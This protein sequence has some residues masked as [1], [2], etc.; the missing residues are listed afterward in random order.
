MKT[1]YNISNGS[2]VIAY[3]D[4]KNPDRIAL[5]AG[6]TEIAPPT[7]DPNT[8][9]CTFDGTQWVVAEIPVP[10]PDPIPEP[11]AAMDQLR[12][13]RNQLLAQTDWR[14]LP[15][16]PG[17]NQTEWQTHRQSLRDITTQTPSLDADGNLTGITWPIP[18]TD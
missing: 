16:Y 18:P 1:V 4:P 10:E 11:I 13:Q 12:M 9:T 6:S 17:T 14:M 15:D 8:H 7:F 3:P 2:E 5:P